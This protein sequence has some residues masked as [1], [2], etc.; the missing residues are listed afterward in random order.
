MYV[1]NL[2]SVIKDYLLPVREASKM[3]S[4]SIT[5]GDIAIIFSNVETLYEVHQSLCTQLATLYTFW[6]N[7]TGIGEFFGKLVIEISQKFQ[8]L[9]ISQFVHYTEYV[10]NFK[11]AVDTLLRI[12]HDN[13]KVNSFFR[14][15]HNKSSK[16]DLQA[17]LTC[18][19]NRISQ[20]EVE[21]EVFH[22]IVNS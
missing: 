4:L 22:P 10:K 5:S 3:K 7:V 17:L 21:L 9:Q 16:L 2:S 1:D 18:P 8:I 11:T 13:E 12:L 14:D 19:L 6:P 15:I 20:Y